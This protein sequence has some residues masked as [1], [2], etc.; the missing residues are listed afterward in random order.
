MG[1]ELI[2]DSAVS[3]EDIR[4]GV[5]RPAAGIFRQLKRWNWV[6]SPAWSKVGL[7]LADSPG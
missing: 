2:V 1:A 6:S 4:R 7:I 3:L 5:A